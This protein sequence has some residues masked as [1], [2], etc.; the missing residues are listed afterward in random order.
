MGRKATAPAGRLWALGL[1]VLGLCAASSAAQADAWRARTILL[2]DRSAGGCAK[3]GGLYALDFTGTTFTGSNANGKMF[4]IT[5]PA[6][7][8]VK[9]AFRSPSGASLEIVGNAKS[10][11]LDIVN[12]RSAC[13]W[14][15]TPE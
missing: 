12:S 1:V 13:R 10:R 7:G 6:D 2:P 8:A 3:T 5:I 9:H 14:K 11:D 15:L 4:S